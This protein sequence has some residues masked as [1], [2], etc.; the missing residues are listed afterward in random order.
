MAVKI[1]TFNG[2]YEELYRMILE[3]W[4]EEYHKHEQPVQEFSQEF[5]E[6]NL[7]RPGFDRDLQICAYIGGELVGFGASMPHKLIRDDE[8]Y[9]AVISSFFTVNS[10]YKGEGIGKKLAIERLHRVKDK[11]FDL[12]YF[13]YDEGHVVEKLYNK[14][15]QEVGIDLRD[16]HS[17]TFLSKSLDSDKLSSLVELTAM[18]RF[19]LPMITERK[20]IDKSS[21]D[22]EVTPEKLEEIYAVLNTQEEGA[23]QV[24]WSKEELDC[25]MKSKCS[26]SMFYKGKNGTGMITFYNVNLLGNVEPKQKQ[27]VTSVDVVAFDNLSR[28]ERYKMVRNFSKYQK[29][30]GSCMIMLPTMSKFDLIPFYADMFIPTGRIHNV[31][32]FDYNSRLE[33][34][35]KV[36]SMIFR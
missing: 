3:S 33:G 2:D 36:K 35:P 18:Q 6:W 23:L 20:N 25:T 11:G 21:V 9:K 13:V 26:D 24:K 30:E 28:W 22:L 16:L 5:I 14:L 17:F 29:D 10:K 12:N 7:N 31:R 4:K 34:K 15:S 27:K 8:E 19:L 32:G 1:K